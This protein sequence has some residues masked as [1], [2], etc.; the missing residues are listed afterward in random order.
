[1]RLVESNETHCIATA[2]DTGQVG[3]YYCYSQTTPMQ[4][5]SCAKIEE[6]ESIFGQEDRGRCLFGF[7]SIVFKCDI[8]I[9][10]G[11]L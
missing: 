6:E 3:M 1:M 5:R 10:M 4:Q 11:N 9:G 2:T 7:Y 8:K